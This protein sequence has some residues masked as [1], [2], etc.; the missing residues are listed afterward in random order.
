LD[1]RHSGFGKIKIQ[2]LFS[3]DVIG[4]GYASSLVHCCLL[5]VFIP[6]FIV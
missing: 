1:G 6:V 5:A 2:W 4:R 3:G